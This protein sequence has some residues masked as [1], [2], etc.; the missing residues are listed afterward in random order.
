[1][2]S[3]LGGYAYAHLSSRL[4][5][6]RQSILHVVLLAQAFWFLPFSISEN[7]LHFLGMEAHLSAPSLW[8]LAALTVTVGIPILVLAGSG[9]MIQRWFGA[10][11]HKEAG[12]PYFLYAASNM[13]SMLA[14]V[15]YPVLIEPGLTLSAQAQSWAIGYAALIVSVLG[16]ALFLFRRNLRGD[17]ERTGMAF[18]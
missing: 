2:A 4:S 11:E 9:P 18:F 8:L 1:Q 17:H 10:T 15:A 13:G 6:R 16:C 14:L 7:A 12:D 3:L 5:P